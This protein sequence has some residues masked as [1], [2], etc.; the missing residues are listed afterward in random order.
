MI[1]YAVVVFCLFLGACTQHPLSPEQME[2][3]AKVHQNPAVMLK[4][5]PDLK[6]EVAVIVAENGGQAL[7]LTQ[8]LKGAAKGQGLSASTSPSS[9]G[10]VV[11]ASPMYFGFLTETEALAAVQEKYGS[12]YE[13]KRVLNKDEDLPEGVV[14]ALVVD[15]QLAARTQAKRVRNNP[16]VVNISAVNTI[17]D[18][19]SSRMLVYMPLDDVPSV[20][21]KASMEKVLYQRLAKVIMQAL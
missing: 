11:I 3:Q 1:K 2:N 20:E 17:V 18:E 9:A 19:N 6:K 10:Y 21:E 8:A 15:V 5:V 16:A 12:P 13:K 7:L 4:D 14:L